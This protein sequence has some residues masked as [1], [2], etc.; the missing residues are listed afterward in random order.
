M[1][2][3][4]MQPYFLPYLTY[5]SLIASADQFVI[6]DPVQ[7][8]RHGWIN[9]NR[10]LKAG[11][12][13]WQ[14]IRVPVAKHSRETP[15]R[16]ITIANHHDWKCKLRAQVDHYRKKAPFYSQAK[17]LLD[18][19][20]DIQTSSIV[21]L[22]IHSLSVLCDALRI[23]FQTVRFSD[24]QHRVDPPQHAGQWALHISKALQATSYINPVGGQAIFRPQEFRR[25]GIELQFLSN[26]LTAYCQRRDH[27]ISGLSIIDVLMFNSLDETRDRIMDD[28]ILSTPAAV[29]KDG[30]AA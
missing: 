21:D 4:A 15:I 24:I 20:L 2:I 19:C 22:N 27:F 7:Y 25:S 13:D 8:I 14:Y 6:F 16:D 5:F 30:V 12:N 23:D 1:R 29:S 28:V 11:I 26:P 10:I 9:R 17:E 3:A 18:H